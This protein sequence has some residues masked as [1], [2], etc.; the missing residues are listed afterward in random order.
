MHQAYASTQSNLNAHCAI[1]VT[2]NDVSKGALCK[3]LVL[4]HKTA[5]CRGF[6]QI[7]EA[8][9]HTNHNRWPLTNGFYLSSSA[10]FEKR[11]VGGLQ[12][13]DLKTH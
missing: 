2:Y 12:T 9:W 8:A 6:V 5:H 7:L 11:A 4:S 3:W 1:G 13:D 10:Q